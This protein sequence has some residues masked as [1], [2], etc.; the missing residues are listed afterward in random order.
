MDS[1]T[2]EGSLA[3]T[4]DIKNVKSSNSELQVFVSIGGWTFSDNDTATQPL[5]P[6]IKF[7]DNLVS[8]M[9]RYGFDGVDLDWKYPG[10]PSRGG[11]EQKDVA[12]YPLLLQTLRTTFESSARGSYGLIFTISASIGIS[13]SECYCLCQ[14]PPAPP[15]RVH[16]QGV[17]DEHN[18]IGSIVQSH[19]NFTEIKL[20]ADLLW[21]NKVPPG[22]LVL[23]VG[24]YSRSFGLRDPE[25]SSPGCRFKGPAKAGD[26]TNPAGAFPRCFD[27][28]LVAYVQWMER[29]GMPATREQLEAV[30]NAIRM[31]RDPNARPVSSSWLDNWR[32]S[33]PA[34]AKTYLKAV[35]RARKSFEAHGVEEVEFFYSKLREIITSY[36]IGSSEIWN[37]DEAGIRIGCLRERIQVLIT[38]TT[39]VKSTR[40]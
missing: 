18:P 17:W 5:F 26:C 14:L 6:A 2:L 13:S 36:R 39:R 3:E 38:R 16:Y 31:R 15:W 22:K 11:L 10:A 20:A 40:P 21:R 24:F 32:G 23:R 30:A 29:T 1:A 33:H 9:A 34:I 7:T 25:C 4:T 8:F 28:A 12:N 35:E 19:T 37:E 27:D